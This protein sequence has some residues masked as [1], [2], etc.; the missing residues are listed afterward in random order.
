MALYFTQFRNIEQKKKITGTLLKQ[1]V[2]KKISNAL[3]QTR[4]CHLI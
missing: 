4:I 2:E 3:G 1:P